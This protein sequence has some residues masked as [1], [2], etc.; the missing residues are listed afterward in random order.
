[1]YGQ[2]DPTFSGDGQALLILP[3]GYSFSDGAVAVQADGKV[4]V[5]GTAYDPELETI[6]YDAL[7]RVNV[8]GTLDKVFV[9]TDIFDF[10]ASDV[11]VQQDGKIL[12]AGSDGISRFNPDFTR[13][14]TFGGGDGVAAGST[15]MEVQPDGK[16]LLAGRGLGVGRLTANGAIDLTFDGDGYNQ[17]STLPGDEGVTEGIVVLND[18]RIVVSGPRPTSGAFA[19]TTALSAY[20]PDGSVDTTF[21]NNGIRVLNLPSNAASESSLT[22]DP[23]QNKLLVSSLI[24]GKLIRVNANGSIDS[25]FAT[26]GV[27]S[28]AVE[29]N[30]YTPR[31]WDSVVMASGTYVLRIDPSNA[32]LR[33]LGL[34]PDGTVDL[35][36]GNAGQTILA[37][38]VA[39]LFP[40]TGQ[41]IALAPDG[42]IVTAS[43]AG[44]L[45]AQIYVARL[46][47]DAGPPPAV[48]SIYGTAGNDV[49][50]VTDTTYTLN[51]RT[52]AI[53]GGVR[54]VSVFAGAGDDRVTNRT[55]RPASLSGQ[56]GDD[57]LIG[58]A[59]SDTLA[60]GQGS[61]SL[62][63]GR[64]NDKY[65]FLPTP[66][67]ETDILNEQANG[68]A[69]TLDFGSLTTSVTIKLNNDTLASHF[70]RTVRV[71]RPGLAGNFEHAIG[72]SGNDLIYGNDAHANA[73]NGGGGNDTIYGL[74]GDD[75][76]TGGSGNDYL[77]GNTGNDTFIAQDGATDS[78]FGG[79]GDDILGSSDAADVIV[80]IP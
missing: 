78:L 42:K 73:L 11:E 29:S 37:S 71:S 53:G 25:S 19:R 77:A 50:D 21:G 65:Q 41:N 45:N 58:G 62:A 80:N 52:Y 48:L 2:F 54:S 27:F 47:G 24:N 12:L 16:I 33:L 35:S 44:F 57:T 55:A 39:A 20:K 36:F 46:T 4:L 59:G 74:G 30:G 72:G 66:I 7:I 22:Y 70:N 10:G 61:D 8:D 38:D 64:G 5:A 60:G 68:D 15:V 40:H 13:D 76:L 31:I 32:P 3:N 26:N 28:T 49:I 43:S 56:A 6:Q 1:M 9:S 14:L 23:L 34:R 67:V 18:G 69:D 63:G 51:G 17:S 75:T 79:K